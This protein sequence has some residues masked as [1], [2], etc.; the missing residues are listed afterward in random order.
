MKLKLKIKLKPIKP[1][2]SSQKGLLK[3]IS[4][5][6]GQ[7][8]KREQKQITNIRH[9]KRDITTAF[10]SMIRIMEY[11]EHFYVNKLDNS[12][13]TDKFLRD[14]LPKFTQ[15]EISWTTPYQVKKLN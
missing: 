4:F 13:E 8:R 1:T 9:Q 14:K 11:Y 3:S 10:T 6:R 12:Y 7:L 5:Q 15:E 2:V